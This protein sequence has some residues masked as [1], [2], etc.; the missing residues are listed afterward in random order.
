MA[1]RHV[2]LSRAVPSSDRWVVCKMLRG[3][4]FACGGVTLYG[5]TWRHT[6]NKPFWLHS[7]LMYSTSLTQVSLIPTVLFVRMY[8]L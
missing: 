2:R 1:R 8:T 7:C 5:V 6:S 4:F 3:L